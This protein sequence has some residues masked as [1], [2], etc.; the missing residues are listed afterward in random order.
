VWCQHDNR[1]QQHNTGDWKNSTHDSIFFFHN[2]KFTDIN[3]ILHVCD[4]EEC[5]WPVILK[6]VAQMP[7]SFQPFKL[8][9]IS[10]KA[11]NFEN[12]SHRV[13]KSL[14]FKLN[15]LSKRAHNFEKFHHNV[16]KIL[17]FKLNCL[18]KRA[19]NFEKFNHNVCKILSFKLNCLSKKAYNFEKFSHSVCKILYFKLNCLSKRAHS[20]ENFSTVCVCLYTHVSFEL[21]CLSKKDHN[22]EKFSQS[23]RVFACARFYLLN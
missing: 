20:F 19:H 13:C 2:D 9:C 16:C 15:C 23:A 5:T 17:F 21:N 11:H 18:S 8:N 7:H 4:K 22:F 1:C 3:V 10:K 6:K 14:S 12:L